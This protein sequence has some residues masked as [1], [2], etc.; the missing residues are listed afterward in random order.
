MNVIYPILPTT[1]LLIMGVLLKRYLQVADEFWTGMEKMVYFVFFPVLLLETTTNAKL[2]LEYI[3]LAL[4]GLGVMGIGIIFSFLGIKLFSAPVKT[5]SSI[6][7]CGFRF[8]TYVGISIVAVALGNEGVSYFAIIAGACVPLANYIAVSALAVNSGRS[9]FR[10]VIKN[11]L[12]IAT[13]SGIVFNLLGLKLPEFLNGTLK[14]ISNATIVLGLIAVGS[15]LHFQS[16][17]YYRKLSVYFISLKL[18]ILP[19]VTIIILSLINVSEIMK[20]VLII[21]AALPTASSAY[22][23]SMRMNGDGKTVALQISVGSVLS[24]FTIPLI[25]FLASWF[26]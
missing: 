16:L 11:P 21:F 22:I 17:G 8:N 12:I 24:L 26:H 6:F 1:I 23:L 9:I 3:P 4:L 25:L 5:L 13:I 15:A 18:L 10:E 19:I 14:L 20:T 2:G 7:Q